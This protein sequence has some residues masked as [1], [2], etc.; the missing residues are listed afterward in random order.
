M[1]LDKFVDIDA[2]KPRA[3]YTINQTCSVLQC[4]RNSLR[5]W[6]ATGRIRATFT[7]NT[8][9]TMYLGSD[10]IKFYTEKM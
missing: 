3:L 10:I 5:N 2:V 1:E 4:H 9:R 6:T 7:K 8:C